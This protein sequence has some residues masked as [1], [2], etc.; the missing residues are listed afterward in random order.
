MCFDTDVRDAIFFESAVLQP[1]SINNEK[2][3]VDKASTPDLK[4]LRDE[5]E[6]GVSS[7]HCSTAA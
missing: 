7:L 6:C 3:D 4:M 1:Q 5:V 2:H